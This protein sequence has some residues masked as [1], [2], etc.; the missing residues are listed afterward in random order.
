MLDVIT[1]TAFRHPL[2]PKS[3][4]QYYC[5]GL[6]SGKRSPDM[7]D[8]FPHEN[9]DAQIVAEPVTINIDDAFQF[10]TKLAKK[11]T[12]KVRASL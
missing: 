8:G 12:T 1:A 2:P 4:L 5:T 7:I 3:R 11:V 6:N 10:L 9:P